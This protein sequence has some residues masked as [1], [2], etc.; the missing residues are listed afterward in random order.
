MLERTRTTTS[1]AG[2]CAE[3][4][5]SFAHPACGN[6]V[7]SQQQHLFLELQQRQFLQQQQQQQRQQ[8]L[9]QEQPFAGNYSACRT[10]HPLASPASRHDELRNMCRGPCVDDDDE[11]ENDGADDDRASCTRNIHN[12]VGNNGNGAA[13]TKGVCDDDDF[14]AAGSVDPREEDQFSGLRGVRREFL[15]FLFVFLLFLLLAG[16][17]VLT[18]SLISVLKL[19]PGGGFPAFEIREDD[20][21]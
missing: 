9:L 18:L 20:L 5:L 21:R 7:S 6:E 17:L 13:P 8:Q 14:T 10:S 12:V 3:S 16:N 15:L 1:G 11:D 2:G 19:T 4:H